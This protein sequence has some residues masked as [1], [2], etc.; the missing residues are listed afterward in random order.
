MKRFAFCCAS[1]IAHS[2]GSMY[3][4]YQGLTILAAI[5]LAAAALWLV[6]GVIEANRA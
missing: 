6:T 4:H 1:S 3:L 2:L 5:A